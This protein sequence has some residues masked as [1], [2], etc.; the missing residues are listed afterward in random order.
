MLT[1]E[2][3]D[4]IPSRNISLRYDETTEIYYC[5]YHG[6]ENV[7]TDIIF[8]YDVKHKK[9]IVETKEYQNLL[10]KKYNQLL[11]ENNLSFDE[12]IQSINDYLDAQF[13]E[14]SIDFNCSSHWTF[15]QRINL[16][17]RNP[18][19]IMPCIHVHG[20]TA[21]VK[22]VDGLV[23]M[24]FLHNL[25]V[26]FPFTLSFFLLIIPSSDSITTSFWTSQIYRSEDSIDRWFASKSNGNIGFPCRST[27]PESV[28]CRNRIKRIELLFFVRFAI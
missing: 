15:F 19:V 18:K 12:Q 27:L 13:G 25:P 16:N 9:W 24:F 3:D 7:P 26:R 4:F 5:F 10:E 8:S 22:C 17:K 20:F 1:V 6:N 28:S 21:Y 23:Q 14:Y 2:E 11:E